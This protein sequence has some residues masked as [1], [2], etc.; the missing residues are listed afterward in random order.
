[1]TNAPTS[2]SGGVAGFCRVTRSTWRH[3]PFAVACLVALMGSPNLGCSSLSRSQTGTDSDGWQYALRLGD[4]LSRVHSLLGFAWRSQNTGS[5]L[6]E[7]YPLSGVS[8]WLDQG[9]RVTKLNF[10]GSAG[11]YRYSG[12]TNWIVS[13]RG[14]FGRLTARMNEAQF[15]VALGIPAIDGAEAATVDPWHGRNAVREH[16][17]VWRKGGFIIDAL[18]VSEAQAS[19]RQAKGSL[20]WFDVSPGL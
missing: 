14:V 6:L 7:E 2:L 12:M 5:G 10:I 8:V 11:A 17:C 19:D 4:D 3:S 13:D 9:N 16:R 15:R 1:M 20:I 18:F